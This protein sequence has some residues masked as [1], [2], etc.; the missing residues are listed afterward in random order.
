MYTQGVNKVLLIG[1]IE[2]EPI[3]TGKNERLQLSFP[4]A[5]AEQV[6][7]DTGVRTC[8]EMQQIRMMGPLAEKHYSLL[9]KGNQIYI[10]GKLQARPQPTGLISEVIALKVILLPDR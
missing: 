5:I 9:N 8:N 3:V 6:M 1:N 10:E 7:S 4:L 2:E